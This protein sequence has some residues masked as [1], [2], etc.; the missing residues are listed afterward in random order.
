MQSQTLATEFNRSRR[1]ININET[2][3][4]KR[5]IYGVLY[6]HQSFYSSIM[7]YMPITALVQ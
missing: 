1:S 7:V 5:V 4:W 6:L 3:F 2:L